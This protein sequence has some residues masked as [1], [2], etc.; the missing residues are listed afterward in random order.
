MWVNRIE[1]RSVPDEVLKTPKKKWEPLDGKLL[2]A[3][4]K[5]AVGTLKK[6]FELHTEEERVLHQ[7]QIAGAFMLRLVC[8]QFQT[9]DT[10]EQFTDIQDLYKVTLKGVLHLP[11]FLYQWSITLNGMQFPEQLHADA[12]LEMF[13]KQ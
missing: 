9:K 5:N 1:S 4:L 7:R 2:A 13:Y 3:L 6:S 8:R 11:D 10:L 12:K